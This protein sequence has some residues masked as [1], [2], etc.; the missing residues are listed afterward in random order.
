MRIRYWWRCRQVRRSC[1]LASSRGL[2]PC[3]SLRT[4]KLP[5]QPREAWT[6]DWIW[7][8]SRRVRLANLGDLLCQGWH[9]KSTP[10]FWARDETGGA[11]EDLGHGSDGAL[12]WSR[13][14]SPAGGGGGS[15]AGE[16]A[17]GLAARLFKQ[18]VELGAA[19]GCGAL[20][21]VARS[22]A[23]RMVSSLLVVESLADRLFSFAATSARDDFV[24]M[25]EPPS[26]TP[27]EPVPA[28]DMRERGDRRGLRGDGMVAV[29]ARL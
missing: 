8:R 10:G 18:R 7:R 6:S 26:G 2:D 14:I 17:V 16:R 1:W 11:E 21:E 5:G 24:L 20:L 15:D 28:S 12:P 22:L 25:D 19:N 29:E 13:S 27:P 9:G 4:T 3:H 23:A